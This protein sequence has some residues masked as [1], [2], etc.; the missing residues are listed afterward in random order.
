MT[1]LGVSEGFRGVLRSYKSSLVN[2][3]GVSRAFRSVLRPFNA[4]QGVSVKFKGFWDRFQERGFP[5][6]FQGILIR[7][8]SAS[9]VI[10]EILGG[11]NSSVPWGFWWGFKLRF[12]AFLIVSV[13]FGGV[14]GARSGSMEVQEDFRSV[15]T[16][17]N[18]FQGD[19]GRIR[20]SSKGF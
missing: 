20:R 19:S 6:A 11:Y 17:F 1:Y 13:D 18:A 8:K 3:I 2:F 9:E 5:E 15:S 16:R 14:L 10:D 7:F 12:N 4:C